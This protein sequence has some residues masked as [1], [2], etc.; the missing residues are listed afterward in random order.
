MTP[1]TV[2]VVANGAAAA[3]MIRMARIRLLPKFQAP[4]CRNDNTQEARP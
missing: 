2:D 3:Q 1:G 4:I